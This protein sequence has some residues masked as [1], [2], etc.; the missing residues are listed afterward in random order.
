VGLNVASE[1]RLFDWGQGRTVGLSR[2]QQASYVKNIRV[3]S[4][5]PVRNLPDQVIAAMVCRTAKDVVD[6][7]IL[8]QVPA[9]LATLAGYAAGLPGLYEAPSASVFTLEAAEPPRLMFERLVTCGVDDLDSYFYCLVDLH[10][11]RLKYEG[12]LSMQ[13]F[14]RIEQV[15]PRAM[16][17]YGQTDP[18]ALAVLLTWRKWIYD[19][20]NRAAQE[21]GY[22]FEPS[23]VSAL[24]GA[25]FPARSSPIRRTDDS[26]KGRQVD[27][28]VETAEGKWAYEFKIR[29]TIAASGQGRWREELS[30]PQEARAAGYTPVLV[31][32]DG[33]PNDKLVQLCTAYQDADGAAYVGEAAWEHVE[34]RSGAVMAVFVDKYLR[35]PLVDLISHEPDR[36]ALP[37]IEFAM[38][39]RQVLITIDGWEPMKIDRAP[40]TDIVVE[41]EEDGLVDEEDWEE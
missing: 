15:G 27:C 13:A 11:R 37:S 30:F 25:S 28:V 29:V 6:S 35:Q 31:V 26:G 16:L 40:G 9:T 20:D 36:G 14:P 39:E 18:A 24:G 4:E 1:Q 23:L 2:E 8:G 17:Q 12:I 21:T 10:K 33:T 38:R 19:I 7:G 34:Q 22:V 32:F 3:S 41:D 5:R